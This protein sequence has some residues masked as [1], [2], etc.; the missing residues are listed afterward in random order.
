MATYRNIHLSF[1]TDSKVDEEFTPEDKY[2]YLWCL[3]N[4]HTNLCGCYEVS[5]KLVSHE[6][7]Y[8]AD[9][10]ERLFKRLDMVH[11]VIRYNSETKE[12]LVLNWHKYNWSRSDKLNKPLLE[13][14]QKVKCDRFREYLAKLYNTRETVGVPYD[15]EEGKAVKK[16]PEPKKVRGKYGWVKLSDAEMERLE[17]DLGARERDRCITYVDESA[18]ATGNKNKWK[19]WNLVVRRCSKYGWGFSS[20]QVR[21]SET[22]KSYDIEELEQMS[23]FDLPDNL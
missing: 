17:Y 11:N 4:P 8:N 10:V 21:T 20:G 5:I 2:G 12:L 13:E 18:Q 6:L 23:H 1:W 15:P 14:I 9:S 19:D 16:E 7:G 3:S 22:P